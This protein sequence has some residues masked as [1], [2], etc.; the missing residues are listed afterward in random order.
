MKALLG[1]IEVSY[2]AQGEGMPVVFVHGLAEGKE[3]WCEIQK[4]IGNFRTYAYDLRGHGE[5][6]LGIG[7]GTI[8]QL[9]DDLV[10]FLEKV[11]GRAQCVGYSLG[12]TLVLWAAAKRPEL[13]S[14]AIVAGTS[15]VV[16]RQAVGF[17]SDR[18]RMIE[19][20]FSAFAPALKK[21]TALQIV[22][23]GVDLEALTARR[24]EAVGNGGGYVNA[25]RAMIGLHENPLT[26]LL[27]NIQ[28]PVSVIGGSGDIFCPRK[29]ADIMLNKLSNGTYQEVNDAGHLMSVDQLENYSNTIHKSLQRRN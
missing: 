9:G 28:C 16:G 20:N 4:R 26:P 6:T 29:A 3:S 10:T 13:V 11:C 24:L 23:S 5:T 1:D 17:F 22:T 8:E 25:A 27:S 15:A 18:I 2:T 19:E 14:A 12:G 7:K 21:D